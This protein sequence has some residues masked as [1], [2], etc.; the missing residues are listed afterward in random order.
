MQ[1]RTH[2]HTMQRNTTP[3]KNHTTQRQKHNEDCPGFV[4]STGE[5]E[6]KKERKCYVTPAFSRTPKGDEIRNGYLAPTFSGPKRERKCY[7]NPTFLGIRKKREMKSEV[8][9]SSLPSPGPK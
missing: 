8:A 6:P 9:T 5:L 1:F 2:M 4:N 3:N 7:V